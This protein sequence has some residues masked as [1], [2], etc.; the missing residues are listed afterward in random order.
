M[1]ED[2]A[3]HAFRAGE[4]HGERIG[5]VV[6]GGG[7]RQADDAPCSLV[8]F[9]RGQHEYE[10]VLLRPEQRLATWM[11]SEDVEG[12]LAAFASAAEP[13]ELN[14]CVVSRPAFTLP[15]ELDRTRSRTNATS[16]RALP[17]QLYVLSA[18]RN[19]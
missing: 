10:A 14:L 7:H 9:T 8:E 11:N 19:V 18:G 3:G 1:A 12:F 2:E 13:V 17:I 6:R 15:C 4:F 5:F 16:L